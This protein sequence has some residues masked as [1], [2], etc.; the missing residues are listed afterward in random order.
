MRL[1]SSN[2]R[3]NSPSPQSLFSK[4]Q[5]TSALFQCQESGQQTYNTLP[6]LTPQPVHDKAYYSTMYFSLDKSNTINYYP[7][8]DSYAKP[9]TIVLTCTLA[10]FTVFSWL[11]LFVRTIMFSFSKSQSLT[12]K[13]SW[14][15]A[16]NTRPVDRASD[17]W[18]DA[19]ILYGPQE[20]N[21]FQ[22]HIH[23][24]HVHICNIIIADKP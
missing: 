10:V 16:L 9:L 22:A 4:Y 18:R 11:L 21:H 3:V 23:N 1:H 7:G 6:P 12:S 24:V 5:W 14:T 15:M 2:I 13:H 8:C 17:A 20:R 19:F